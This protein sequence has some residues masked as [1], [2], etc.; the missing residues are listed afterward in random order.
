[1][2]MKEVITA[3]IIVKDEEVRIRKTIESIRDLVAEI[4][5]VDDN[6]SDGTVAVAQDLGAKLV[7]RALDND[8]AAQRNFGADQAISDWVLMIDADEVLPEATVIKL[9]EM[10]SQEVSFDAVSFSIVNVLFE[11]PLP[12]SGGL[13]RT[14]RLY[15]RSRCRFEGGVHERLQVSGKLI[16]LDEQIHNYPCKSIDYQFMKCLRYTEMEA[17]NVVGA[18]SYVSEREICR[19]LMWKSLKRFW[20]HYV[21]RQG[22]REGLPGLVWCVMNVIGSQIRWIK[23][24][25]QAVK[26]NKLGK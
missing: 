20:K 2:G 26:Q 3:V 12:R 8:F 13:C 21:K 7:A 9:R 11:K 16:E 24:W 5:V 23:I 10:F 22:F 6:S 15:R 18:V 25:E 17:K 14:V 1:M 4:V 19:E